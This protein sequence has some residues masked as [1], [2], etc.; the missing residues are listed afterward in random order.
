MKEWPLLSNRPAF[1]NCLILVRFTVDQEPIPGRLWTTQSPGW[2]ITEHHVRAHTRSS[3]ATC[4]D[5]FGRKC[6]DTDSNPSTGSNQDLGAQIFIQFISFNKLF[7]HFILS[8]SS[9]ML[10]VKQSDFSTE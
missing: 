6:Y 4:L 5:V 1:S 2:C 3:Q 7:H 8:P 10:R 9:V